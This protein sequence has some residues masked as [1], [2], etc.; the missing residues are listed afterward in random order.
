MN[1]H[2]DEEL[3]VTSARPDLRGQAPSV[4]TGDDSVVVQKVVNQLEKVMPAM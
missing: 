4:T 1:A 3:P 2:N